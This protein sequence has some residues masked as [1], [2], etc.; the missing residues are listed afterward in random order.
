MFQTQLADLQADVAGSMIYEVNQIR[1]RLLAEAQ[2]M[3]MSEVA[4]INREI[5]QLGKACDMLM[6]SGTVRKWIAERE[7]K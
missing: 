6:F 2:M 3:T 5:E 1:M 7:G 4:A